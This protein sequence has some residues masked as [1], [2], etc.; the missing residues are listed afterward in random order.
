MKDGKTSK[1]VRRAIS[2]RPGMHL[3]IA[4]FTLHE[5]AEGRFQ[6]TNP[7]IRFYF[8]LAASGYWELRSPQRS[9]SEKH[10]S[11]NDLLSTAFFYP[12][13]EGKMYLPPDLRQFHLSIAVEPSVLRE[14][15]GDS[16]EELPDNLRAVS[17][18]CDNMGFYHGGPLSSVM[19]EAIRQLLDSPY[20]GPLKQMYTESKVIEL[21]AH[22][23]AQ[24]ALPDAK[25]P[26]PRKMRPDDV[27]RVRC[28]KEILKRDLERPPKLLDLA[29][30]V[31]TNH[32]ALN[33]GFREVF[34]STVFGC[35]REMRLTEAKRLLEEEDMNVT[36]AALTVGYN[37]IPT[38]SRSFSE[39]FGRN[40][41]MCLKKKD[42]S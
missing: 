15:L 2:L 22:K 16:I 6:S 29:H 9:S 7:V 32:T 27:E 14:Y 4:D 30:T 11:H 31:G 36:E 17:E 28:A 26:A 37:S 8:H 34:G 40:P 20:S 41:K 38:F 19:N 5:A 25:K 13:L 10:I 3:Q 12:E 18:G 33:K 1:G 21:I 23:L 35:L 42:R 39:F 24:I